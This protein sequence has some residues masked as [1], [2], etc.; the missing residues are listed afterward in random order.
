MNYEKKEICFLKIIDKEKLLVKLYFY[1]KK[2]ND[3]NDFFLK[4]KFI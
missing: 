3:F 1:L 2:K 4:Y